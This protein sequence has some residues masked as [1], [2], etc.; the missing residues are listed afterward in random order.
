MRKTI[1]QMSFI[2]IST[3]A[4]VS[5]A[6]AVCVNPTVFTD[7][8]VDAT[9]INDTINQFNDNLGALNPFEP[10]SLGVGRRSINWDAAPDAVSA[11]NPFPGDFFNAGFSPRARGIEFT[12]SGDG[13]QLSAT[14]ASGEGIEFANL[15][16]NYP[17]DFEVFS[18]ERLFTAIGSN[19]ING[20]FF[21]PGEK[22]PAISR[23]FGAIF[24]DVDNIDSTSIEFFDENGDSFSI[25][26]VPISPSGLS[27]LG[28]TYDAPCISRVRIVSGNTAP[29]EDDGGDVDIV[30]MDDFIFGEP[31]INPTPPPFNINLGLAGA[32]FNPATA[33]QGFLFDLLTDQRQ[34]FFLTWF[35][36][37]ENG[38]Q[39]WF[40]A[41]GNFADD[42][43]TLELIEAS[44]GVFNQA[45][46]V[47]RTVVGTVTTTFADCLNGTVEFDIP[48]QGVNGVIPITRIAGDQICQAIVDGDLV[49]PNEI[50]Q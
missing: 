29:G 41:G 5:N 31:N 40:T 22:T 3:I 17:N 1:L 37:T 42:S 48:E 19:V 12:S 24:T 36:F 13:F 45:D 11:P 26:P 4:I 38:E 44:D 8:G 43:S 16:A 33:G 9:A 27:F 30:V 6:S 39:Q 23:G 10:G 21:I 14:Q 7:N 15:N 25:M 50:S 47:T 35:T 49:I 46:P 18:A 28:V 34:F 20:R 32:W 2:S